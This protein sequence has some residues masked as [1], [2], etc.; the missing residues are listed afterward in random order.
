VRDAL[1]LLCWE[2]DKRLASIAKIEEF[3]RG[4]DGEADMQRRLLQAIRG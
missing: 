2:F 4:D 3:K 1:D